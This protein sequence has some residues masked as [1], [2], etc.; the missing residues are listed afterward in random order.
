MATT[1][2][3]P[4]QRG[5]RQIDMGMLM[6]MMQQYGPEAKRRERM[7]AQEM[8]L[9]QQE[10]A[11]REQIAQRQQQVTEAE[12]ARMEDEKGFFAPRASVGLARENQALE[13]GQLG[14]EQQRALLPYAAPGAS[15]ELAQR[16]QQL[17]T[18]REAI[19]QA[20][21]QGQMYLPQ[22]QAQLGGTLLGNEQAAFALEQA[23]AQAAA[24][25]PYLP[26]LAGNAF[27]RDQAGTY[28]SQQSAPL[29]VNAKALANLQEGAKAAMMAATPELERE[30]L[31]QQ[32]LATI[33]QLVQANPDFARLLNP[34]AVAQQSNGLLRM[35]EQ[36]LPL[37][38]FRQ[39]FLD[40]VQNNPSAAWGMYQQASPQYQQALALS[41]EQLVSLANDVPPQD[42]LQAQGVLPPTPGAWQVVSGALGDAFGA[43]R[44]QFDLGMMQFLQDPSVTA[45]P[46]MGKS[47][48]LD[49]PKAFLD[50]LRASLKN[51][52]QQAVDARIK[53]MQQRQ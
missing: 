53:A 12:L 46:G 11:L 44:Q 36:Q 49:Q 34:D 20:I 4:R 15:V 23:R 16:L 8:G 26:D 22:A 14:I 40:T 9:R 51:R 31:S 33:M 29:D 17:E 50:T 42:Y 25:N 5:K 43:A 52:G 35:P 28:V 10:L 13:A 6:S 1:P 18:Q 38:D 45:L 30:R 2:N 48:L 41:P 32:G 3:E 47:G 27:M 39:Q 19:Q 21:Q 37:P 24:T 7:D